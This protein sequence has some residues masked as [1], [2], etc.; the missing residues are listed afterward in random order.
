MIAN[1]INQAYKPNKMKNHNYIFNA[2]RNCRTTDAMC[3]KNMNSMQIEELVILP[4]MVVTESPVAP[5]LMYGFEKNDINKELSFIT[6]KEVTITNANVDAVVEN[7]RDVLRKLLNDCFDKHQFFFKGLML[8]DRTLFLLYNVEIAYTE[9]LIKSFSSFSPIIFATI[10]EIVNEQCVHHY[11]ISFEACS[12]FLNNLEMCVLQQENGSI[13]ET[14]SVYYS[15]SPISTIEYDALYSP[16]K[17][18]VEDRFKV[19]SLESFSQVIEE[20]ERRHVKHG[21]IRSCVFLKRN[22]V[23]TK[24]VTLDKMLFSNCDS[25]SVVTFDKNA[26]YIKQSDCVVTL[27]YHII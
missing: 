13:Y 5:F 22:C 17:K 19:I 2:L 4:Y 1:K 20:N 25:V 14:P 24:E 23:L 16:P 27:S 6:K 10:S 18:I 3:E 12:M 11:D 15:S 7:S 8:V 9:M 26:H 21:F